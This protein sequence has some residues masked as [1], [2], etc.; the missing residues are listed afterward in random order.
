MAPP[1]KAYTVSHGGTALSST[2]YALLPLDLRDRWALDQLVAP[3][4][5]PTK[6][7]LL[8][9]ECVFCYLPLADSQ[10]V[11]Q[12][13]GERFARCAAVLYEMCGLE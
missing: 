13:F 9:A 4:L 10:F 12:W 2:K 11:I 1:A 6:P 5:D 3:L 8:I 7:T